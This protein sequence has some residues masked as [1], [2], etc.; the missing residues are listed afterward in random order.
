[1]ARLLLRI[2]SLAICVVLSNAFYPKDISLLSSKSPDSFNIQVKVATMGRMSQIV[3]R[4]PSLTGARMVDNGIVSLGSM[5]AAQILVSTIQVGTPPKDFVVHF[6]TGSAVFWLRSN[7]CVGGNNC[8][9]P[10]MATFTPSSSSS[11]SLV[12]STYK[13]FTYA[14]GT[15]VTCNV[16]QDIL[17]IGGLSIPNQQLCL[18]NSITSNTPLHDG[19]IGLAP[20]SVMEPTSVFSML[21]TNKAFA[22]SQVS[23][24]YNSS[25]LVD[26]HVQSGVVTVGGVDP[27]LFKGDIRWFPAMLANGRH[28]SIPLTN[29][30]LRDGSKIVPTQK[31]LFSPPLIIIDSGSTYNFLPRFMFDPLNAIHFQAKDIDGT[32]TYAFDC[33]AVP[34]LSPIIL[35]LAGVDIKIM[36]EE[37]YFKF[38]QYCIILFTT[39]DRPNSTPLLGVGFMRFRYTVFDHKKFK[40]GF[41]TTQTG[42]DAAVAIVSPKSRNHSERSRVYSLTVLTLLAAGYL[43]L[44]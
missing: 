29:I 20:P 42:N 23:F 22:A 14:D 26:G 27:S 41:S 4:A 44:C 30:T 8:G 19:I 17:S 39:S 7:A 34:N 36:P 24:W 6:D 28:W 32:G 10:T 40:I 3:N 31:D 15:A 33:N 16:G 5:A 9:Q 2:A 38:R 35:T 12:N 21:D 18:A 43:F 11:F 25:S 13:P 1:M 37:Q